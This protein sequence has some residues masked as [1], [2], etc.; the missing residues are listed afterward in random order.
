[1]I[2]DTPSA[3]YEA[4]RQNDVPLLLGSNSDET[5]LD[6][7]GGIDS[8]P[9]AWVR[10]AHDRYGSDADEFL[11][12]YPGGDEEAVTESRLRSGTDQAM[13]APMRKWAM[14]AASSGTSPVYPYYFT[15]VQ[16]DADLERFGAYHGS[17][18][19][20]AY[21]NLGADGDI[22][23]TNA[24]RRL[25]SEMVDYWLNFVAGGDPN[26][27]DRVLWPTIQEAPESVLE[28][29]DATVVTSRPAARAVD[30]WLRREG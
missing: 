28:L 16:P 12:L 4:G 2:P 22:R 25:E 26:G 20:Y 27:P 6:L 5:S 1:M 3:I 23:Y 15:R 30:F 13:T 9:T 24:D 18:V 29:G 7:I 19:M 17:E 8:D 21:G 14:T 11:E 10:E